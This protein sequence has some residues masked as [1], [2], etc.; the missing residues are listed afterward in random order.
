MSMEKL[1]LKH[2]LNP[3][4]DKMAHSLNIHPMCFHK[5]IS[6]I[7]QQLDQELEV[8]QDSAG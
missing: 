3:E 2:K 4:S 5:V 1:L 7:S 6:P 8:H